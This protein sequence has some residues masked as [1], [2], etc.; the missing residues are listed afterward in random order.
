MADPR[1]PYTYACDFIRQAAGYGESGMILSR[2]DASRIRQAIATAIGM[3]D[4]ELA[5]K[6]ADYAK[7]NEEQLTQKS[8]QAFMRAHNQEP[9]HD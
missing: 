6:L 9:H 8:A 5:R 3:P 7:A 2:A 4:D 1:Y